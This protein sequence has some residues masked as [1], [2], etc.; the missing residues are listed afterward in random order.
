MTLEQEQQ[1][2]NEQIGALLSDR[3]GQFV[4]FKNGK[5]VDFFPN[6]G[7]AYKAG[8]EK[9]GINEVFLVA[10]VEPPRLMPISLAWQAGVMFR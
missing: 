4:L 2:F 10:P 9:F 7:A 3:R 1:A 8:L 6:H 5:P